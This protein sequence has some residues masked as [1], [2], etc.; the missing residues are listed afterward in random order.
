MI[1]DV[2]TLR[3]NAVSWDQEKGTWRVFLYIQKTGD[4]VFLPIPDCLKLVLDALPLPRNA[5][6]GSLLFLE[7]QELA[8]DCS[9]DRRAHPFSRIQEIG[10][11]GRPTLIGIVIPWPPASWS[12]AP[13]SLAPQGKTHFFMG[14]HGV[15]RC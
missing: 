7:R 6:Q 10:S 1:A 15:P 4:S 11:K 3:K 12:R 13:P 9:R 2:C 8:P 14:F 5:S